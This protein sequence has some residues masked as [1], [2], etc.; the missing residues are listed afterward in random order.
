[1]IRKNTLNLTL[2]GLC[3]GMALVLPFLTGQIPQV[4][5]MLCPMHLPVLLCGYLCGWPFGLFVGLA[6]PLLRSLIFGMPPFYPTAVAMAFE[7][8]AY[9]FLTGLLSRRFPRR[10]PFLYLSLVLSMLGGRAVWGV[11]QFVLLNLQGTSFPFPAFLAGAFTNALPGILLQ[12]ILI[13]PLVLAVRRL[14]FMQD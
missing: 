11:V 14:K 4:G 13:P 3:L 5:S 9:G 2:S 12:L 7:L 10:I 1:M 8:A 6:A